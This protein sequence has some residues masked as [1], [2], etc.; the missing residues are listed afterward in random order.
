MLKVRLLILLVVLFSFLA[1]VPG[2]SQDQIDLNQ[3][4]AYPAGIFFGYLPLSPFENYATQ[5]NVFEFSGGLVIP[6]SSMP[7][8]QPFIRGGLISFDYQDINP[9]L[10]DLWDHNHFFGGLGLNLA[11]RFTKN[12]E[13]GGELFAAYTHAVFND[14]VDVPVGYSNIMGRAGVTLTLSPA[15]SLCININPSVTYIYSLGALKDYDG[16]MFGVGFGI[17][18]R[19]GEDPDARGTS[20]RSIKLSNA[21]VQP[22]FG[23]MQSY[24]VKH[25]LGNVTIN[26]IDKYPVTD[27]EVTFFQKDYMDGPTPA[28]RFEQ[29]QPEESHVVDLFATFNDRIFG[30]EGITPLTGEVKV[31]YLSRGK[32][33]EQVFS[34]SYD[35]YDKTSLTWDDT[36][37]VGAFVTS[38]DSA[39]RNYSSF[40]RQV[41]KDD[42]V[43][44][45]SKNLQI[46]IQIYTGLSELGILY[47][48]D[49]TSPFTEAQGNPMV[50]DSISLPRSTMSRLTGDCDDLTALYCS[51]LETVGIE[52]AFITVPGHIYAAFNSG[53]HAKDFA[54]L[55]PN[56]DMAIN[57]EGNLWVP[58]EITL[59]GRKG[60]FDAWNTGIQEWTEV[61]D[62]SQKGMDFTRTAWEEFRPVGLK[63]TDL[64]LQYS[65][66]APGILEGFNREMEIFSNLLLEPLSKAVDEAP[67]FKAYN[68][69]GIAAARMKRYDLAEQSFRNAIQ[70]KPQTVSVRINIGSLN[71]LQEL[72]ETALESYQEAI[73]I[74]E[75]SSRPKNS[76]MATVLLNQSKTYYEMSNYEKAGELFKQAEGLDEKV[77][78]EYRYLG[79]ASGTEGRAS[80]ASEDQEIIFLEDE[81]F[82]D[83]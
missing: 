8:L 53:V 49:P 10:Q 65:Q 2:F 64:G 19:F 73:E 28:A 20:I 32:T 40:V 5:F 31:A 42:V 57:H 44:S 41:C 21:S 61:A 14:L 18:Y 66:T 56:R 33:A 39:V 7:A 77:V 11:T 29:I 78:A 71:F 58:V 30:T 9:E 70:F 46:A 6:F 69:Y 51:L 55:H 38:A 81:V 3:Y 45:V 76:L 22:V 13:I 50:V 67:S 25:P 82:D 79:Q 63:E 35:L 27:V 48:P 59:M 72:Y 1:L 62:Q 52:T 80:D 68:A 26:N 54:R 75:Q 36:R 74:L 43:P 83:E 15:Y 16:F 34:V 23:A 60:F 37:K 17:S 4:Y 24:Y 47:Q 12:F